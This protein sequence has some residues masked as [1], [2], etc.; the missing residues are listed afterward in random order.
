MH[1]SE[2]IQGILKFNEYF[3]N[4]SAKKCGIVR[5]FQTKFHKVETDYK[6]ITGRCVQEA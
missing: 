2:N 1:N 5:K 4:I 6:K 3:A